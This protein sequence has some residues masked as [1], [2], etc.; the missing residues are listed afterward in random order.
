MKRS[1][2]WTLLSLC[3]VAAAWVAWNPGRKPVTSPQR[4]PSDFSSTD[5]VR[6]TRPDPVLERESRDA[7]SRRKIQDDWDQLIAWL[8]SE[9]R[10]GDEEIQARLLATRVAWTE[11]DLQVLS[12]MIG[13]L[14]ESGRDLDTG[15]AFRVGPHGFLKSW[16]T[17]RVFL[18]DVLAASDPEMAAAIARKVLD[19][20]SSGDEYAVAMRSLTRKGM[21]RAS[22]TELL[23]RFQSMLGRNEWAKSSGFAEAFDLPRLLGSE[24]AAMVLLGWNGTPALRARALDELAADAP[25]AA[26]AAVAEAETIDPLTR[27]SLM[28]RANPTDPAQLD[29]VDRYLRTPGLQPAESGTFLNLFP[30]RSATTGFRLY[31]KSPAPYDYPNVVASD[32][33]A[34]EQV[35]RWLNDPGLAHLREPLQALQNRLNEWQQQTR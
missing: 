33:A 3:V 5:R 8:E 6:S 31:G 9:P 27:A 10:P 2:A 15:L 17:L 20:T 11:A 28:A 21:G 14:L 12:E 4:N 25:A 23:S 18:L 30:L 24:D 19:S 22:D 29:A 34:L 7:A 16:P 1:H 26:I 13:R 32:R 35:T